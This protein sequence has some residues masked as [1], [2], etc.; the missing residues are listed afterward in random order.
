VWPIEDRIER[1]WPSEDRVEL[2]DRMLAT[3]PE[4]TRNLMIGSHGYGV[5]WDECG[6]EYGI[7]KQR[8]HQIVA[9][10]IAGLAERYREA[11]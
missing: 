9:E 8:A 7:S 3:L 5:P 6:A 1:E 10:A 11:R 2:L 4:R